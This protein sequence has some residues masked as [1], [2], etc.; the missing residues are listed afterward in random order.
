MHIFIYHSIT[1]SKL[2][3][4]FLMLTQDIGVVSGG[5]AAAALETIV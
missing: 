3:K 2:K 4:I 5:A 1:G